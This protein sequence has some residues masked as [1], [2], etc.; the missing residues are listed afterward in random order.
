M[1]SGIEPYNLITL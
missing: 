1:S